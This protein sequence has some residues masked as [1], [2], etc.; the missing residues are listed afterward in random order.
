VA[1]TL[2]R[3]A[4]WPLAAAAALVFLVALALHGQRPE[5]GL[6]SFKAGGLFTSFPPEQAQEVEIIRAGKT[7]RFM[8]EGPTWR[9]VE[10]AGPVPRE[11]TQGIDAALRLLRNSAPL[12]T[13]TAEEVGP[14]L[15]PD[16]GLGTDALRVTVRGPA[17]AS[18]VIRFGAPNPLGSGRYT[19]V[20]GMAG[21]PLLATY[22]AESWQQVIG[23]AKP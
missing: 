10:A 3:R 2:I 18:F 19:Q 8:R 17:G 11:A 6:A 4:A 9:P 22:V 15:P 16:Y 12:R 5:A 14:S 7:W 1:S 13:I 21:V 23:T 20:E